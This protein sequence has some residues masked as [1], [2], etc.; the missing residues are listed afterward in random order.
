MP[1][2]LHLSRPPLNPFPFEPRGPFREWMKG[3]CFYCGQTVYRMWTNGGRKHNQYTKDHVFP[4]AFRRLLGSD[5][6]KLR[7][8]TV[9]ACLRCNSVKKDRM[10]GEVTLKRLNIIVVR[11]RFIFKREEKNDKKEAIQISAL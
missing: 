5:Q 8:L 4:Y 6:Q 1:S 11:G 3:R 9:T 7:D 10:P 2:K